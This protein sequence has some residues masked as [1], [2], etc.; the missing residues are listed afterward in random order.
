MANLTE[1][2]PSRPRVRYLDIDE[3]EAGQ[4]IDNFLMSRLKGLPRSRVYRLLRRGE[5]RVN[6]GRVRA[7]YR[8]EAGDEGVAG[9]VPVLG[10]RV[11]SDAPVREDDHPAFEQ[12]DVDKHAG[13]AGGGDGWT[14]CGETERAGR[15]CICSAFRSEERRVGK[16]C[17]CWW[18]GYQ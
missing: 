18:S 17:R 13:A 5:V 14:G 6:G 8:L 2:N 15:V 7:E 4:R 1:E 12:G 16:E 3:D 9:A 10:V 11:G